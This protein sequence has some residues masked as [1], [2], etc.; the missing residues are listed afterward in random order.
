[1]RA[2]S[3]KE[4][5]SLE[6]G[7]LVVVCE[8]EGD[9]VRRMPGYVFRFLHATRIEIRHRD[10]EGRLVILPWSMDTNKPI[11]DP[12]SKLWLEHFE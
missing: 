7:T 4:I 9:S 8:P 10:D 2:I 3:P 6:K 1:M 5:R 11:N 12:K